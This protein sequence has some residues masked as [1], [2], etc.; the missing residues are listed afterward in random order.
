MVCRPV[1]LRARLVCR[2]VD[3]LTFRPLLLECVTAPRLWVG[4]L[5]GRLLLE[6]DVDEDYE[7]EPIPGRRFR[8]MHLAIL[9]LDALSSL[10]DDVNRLLMSHENWKMDRKQVENQMRASIESIVSPE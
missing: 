4:P 5:R 10:V 8:F 6:R 9:A 2:P 1:L 7:V 3:A